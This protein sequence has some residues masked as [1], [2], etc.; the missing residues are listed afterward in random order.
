MIPLYL[1]YVLISFPSS[2]SLVNILFF[3]FFFW[4]ANARNGLCNAS[5]SSQKEWF[6]LKITQKSQFIPGSK[7]AGLNPF[8]IL[9]SLPCKIN[10][11]DYYSLKTKSVY[12]NKVLFKHQHD[13]NLNIKTQKQTHNTTTCT[14]F[15]VS[16]VQ[17]SFITHPTILNYWVKA[18]YSN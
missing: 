9:N 7:L 3:F 13:T 1:A 10:K 12:W 8:F 17:F 4:H 2:Q 14:C 11:I 15:F 6:V 18:S 5:H 16:C